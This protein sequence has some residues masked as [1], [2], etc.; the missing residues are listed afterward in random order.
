MPNTTFNSTPPPNPTANDLWVRA[1]PNGLS[2]E[3]FVHDGISW[4]GTTT[5]DDL[6]NS[7]Q[8]CINFAKEEEEVFQEHEDLKELWEEYLI[9]RRLKL[10]R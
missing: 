3:V 9:T 6:D 4:K 5:L 1:K 10:G 8:H 2:V 7:E